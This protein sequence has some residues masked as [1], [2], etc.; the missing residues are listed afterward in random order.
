MR[1][2]TWNVR[3]FLGDPWALRRVVR[4]LA[5]DVL[6]L[7]EAPRR[8]G[9]AWRIARFA[10]DC[11]LL[12]VAG[13]RASGGTAL[14]VAPGVTVRWALAERLPVPGR[15][16]RTRGLVVAD[17]T[18]VPASGPARGAAERRLPAP[19]ARAGPAAG[20]RAG[21]PRPPAVPAGPARRSRVTSTRHPGSRSGSC[22][23]PRVGPDPAPASGPTFPAGREDKRLDVVLAGAGLRVRRTATGAQTQGT[24]AGAPTTGPSWPTWYRA[25][26]RD[27]TMAPSSPSSW[28]SRGSRATSVTNPPMKPPSAARTTSVGSVCD[29]RAATS[30]SSGPPS[31]AQPRQPGDEVRRRDRRRVGRHEPVVAVVVAVVPVAGADA[32]RR[33]VPEIGEIGEICEVVGQVGPVGQPV[34]RPRPARPVPATSAGVA[35]APARGRRRRPSASSPAASSSSSSPRR[36]GP[37]RRATGPRRPLPAGELGHDRGERRL[38]VELRRVVP[39]VLGRGVA[40]PVPVAV[41]RHETPPAIRFDERERLLLDAFR[42]VVEGRDV[43]AVLEDDLGDV[44]RG[45]AREHERAVGRGHHVVLG[46]SAAGAAAGRR[47]PRPADDQR[48]ALEHRGEGVQRHLV[49]A[50]LG[51]PRLLDVALDRRERRHHRRSNGRAGS[52]GLADEHGGVDEHEPGDV[53]AVLL[54]EA[55]GEG[56]AHR[57]PGH[58]DRRAPLAQLA[59][60]AS[61]SPYHSS[62]VVRFISCQVVPW[63]GSRGQPHAS[64]RPRRAPRPSPAGPGGSP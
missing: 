1:L 27:Q 62:Q 60:R 16:T 50:E 61:T 47:V 14:L 34:P 49:V 54:G 7:Q 48:V 28:P 21:R 10:R 55:E 29:T 24:S 25:R 32:R 17:L 63:P 22:S 53:G 64:D 40:G 9:G 6:C 30:S 19:A 15:L 4:A 37:P 44:A 5:P 18:V 52:M 31:D 11:G 2:V 58:E 43:I 26:P 12:H 36:P 56:T 57:E 23:R 3:D 46:A 33:P 8:P 38:D 41:A 59:E 13:G 51:H 45:D 39:L 35:P 42:V 20:A